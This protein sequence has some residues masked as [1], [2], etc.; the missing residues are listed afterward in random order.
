MSLDHAILGFVNERP[1]SGYDLK[2]AFDA[3]VAH[4]WPANQS[5]IYRTLGRLEAEG[6]VKVRVI[7]QKRKPNRN[8]YHITERGLE[9]LRRWLAT[10]LPL[11]DVR[12]AFLVQLFF[13]DAITLE[14]IVALLES[15]ASAHRERL[16]MY[17][18]FHRELAKDPPKGEWDKT[19]IPLIVDAG[20]SQQE[21]WLEWID[22]AL[23]RVKK[24][25]PRTGG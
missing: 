3:T 13:A 19:L 21:A 25:P 17:R 6:L 14:Q 23:K 20:I 18:R 2:K 24:L 16:E 8:V 15:R 1:R 7:P 9:E 5:Q 4:I 12:E 11:S 10:P 22:Q